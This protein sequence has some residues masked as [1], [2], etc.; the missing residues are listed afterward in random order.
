MNPNPNQISFG[1]KIH[2]A[3]V[4]VVFIAGILNGVLPDLAATTHVPAW[5]GVII[6]AVVK[7]GNEFLSDKPAA[8]PAPTPLD[9]PHP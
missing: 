3:I 6:A 4:Q 5:V 9:G 1:S 7:I 8:P 2:N